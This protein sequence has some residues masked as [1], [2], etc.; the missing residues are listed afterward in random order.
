M[1]LNNLT[2][3][4]LG[5]AALGG[6]IGFWNQIKRV[7]WKICNLGIQRVYI[8]QPLS[9]EI[10]GYLVQHGK[11]SAMYDKMFG[12]QDELLKNGNTAMLPYEYFGKKPIFFRLG[13]WPV[14]YSAN[15]GGNS[16]AQKQAP[17]NEKPVDNKSCCSLTFIRGTI[18][19]D[20]IIAKASDGCNQRRWCH[21][22]DS[23]SKQRR[24]FIEHFPSN[25]S[26]ASLAYGSEGSSGKWFSMP[27]IRLIG[28]TENEIG[29]RIAPRGS[30]LSNLIFPEHIVKLI[31]EIKIWRESRSWYEGKCI[32]WKRGWALFGPPGCVLPDTKIRVRK[33]SEEGKHQLI[34]ESYVAGRSMNYQPMEETYEKPHS[35][36]SEM[37]Q[38]S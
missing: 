9:H 8:D 12:G 18:D 23:K 31:D 6:I 27:S 29:K 1:D 20:K 7:I 13:K 37:Q 36:L 32:P 3:F 35:K 22:S 19:V 34:H 15:N 14:I 16:D 33:K 24:F 38:N 26:E 28:Y 21:D 10:I 25:T 17:T 4:A 2:G 30:A 11:R 5:G